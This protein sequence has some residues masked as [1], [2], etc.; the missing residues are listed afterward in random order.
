ML[1]K[2]WA[3]SLSFKILGWFWLTLMVSYFVASIAAFIVPTPVE[4]RTLPGEDRESIAAV[5]NLIAHHALTEDNDIT[6]ERDDRFV[7][8]A[9]FDDAGTLLVATAEAPENTFEL[10]HSFDWQL[11]PIELLTSHYVITGPALVEIEGIGDIQVVFWRDRYPRLID[12][13]RNLP[14]WFPLM[15]AVLATFIMSL[16]FYRSIVKPLQRISTGFNRLS[17]GDL[18][19]RIGKH[20]RHDEFGALYGNFD[21]MAGQLSSLIKSQHRLSADISHELKT[22]LSRMQMA[23]ALARTASAEQ[24]DG[25]LDRAESEGVKLDELIKQ[26]LQLAEIKSRPFDFGTDVVSL[27][28]LLADLI[29]D[30]QFEADALNLMLN[31]EVEPDL[32]VTVN[33][34][35]LLMAVENLIRNAFK[36]A[37]SEVSFKVRKSNAELIFQISDDGPG[38]ADSEL[39]KLQQPFYRADKSRDRGTGGVG[40]GLAIAAEAVTVHQGQLSLEN[41][42]Q[43]GLCARISLAVVQNSQT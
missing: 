29:D 36:Y 19:Y 41:R 25:Y 38:V 34:R 16:L 3:G 20:S 17:A 37:H 33:A 14:A 35:L 40:L 6:Q 26:L 10:I 28:E 23:L 43:G 9:L 11:G 2:S 30:A 39:E 32:K 7:D 4:Q 18:D 15:L 24:L 42:D 12:R 5:A 27:D 21:R 13:I 1:G 31:I 8:W 22:P